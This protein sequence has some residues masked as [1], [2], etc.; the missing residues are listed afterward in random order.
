MKTKSKIILIIIFMLCLLF[1]G[2]K[3]VQAQ[4]WMGTHSVNYEST[5]GGKRRAN[6]RFKYLPRLPN[7]TAATYTGYF[8]M[9]DLT[10]YSSLYS[11]NRASLDWLTAVNVYCIQH[12]NT[13]HT[14]PYVNYIHFDLGTNY[15]AISKVGESSKK[16]DKT[17][18]YA[19]W[20]AYMLSMGPTATEANLKYKV[21]SLGQYSL[22]HEESWIQQSIWKYFNNFLKKA[23]EEGVYPSGEQ[24]CT[25]NTEG[26]PESKAE[27]KESD[28][29]YNYKVAYQKPTQVSTTVKTTKE[30]E[31]TFIGPFKIKYTTSTYNGKLFGGIWAS[32]TQLYDSDGKA[33]DKGYWVL[34]D[35]TKTAIEY[36][37]SNSTFYLKVYTPA[38]GNGLSKLK[39]VMSDLC[40][41]A[42][43]Y[44]VR[45]TYY[46]S[47]QKFMILSNAKTTWVNTDLNIELQG[48]GNIEIT[49]KD[50][51]KGTALE[52]FGFKIYNTDTKKYVINTNP[53]TYGSSSQATVFKTNASGKISV[54]GLVPGDYQA[55]E[56]SV[57]D[58]DG[59]VVP[60]GNS[61]KTSIT[62]SDGKTA[63]K[64]IKNT[65]QKGNLELEK[66]NAYNTNIKLENVE[67]AIKCTSGTQ[68]GKYVGLNSK[69]EVYYSTSKITI[70]T[71]KNGKISIKGIWIGTY[72]LE[73]VSNPHY[74]YV[75]ETVGDIV[76]SSHK[77]TSKQVKNVPTYVKISGYVWLD[78]QYN[79][80]KTTIRN[81][82]Y[83]DNSSDKNDERI[84]GIKVSLMD[85]DKEVKTTTTNANGE[86][87]FEDAEIAKLDDYNIQFEYDGLLYQNVKTN[88]NKDNGSKA[89]EGGRQEFN[90]RF[91]SIERGDS[92]S[93]AVALNSNG[94]EEAKVNYTF[95]QENGG[96]YAEIEST[97][98][99]TITSS[100]KDAK[101]EIPFDK[102]SG[103]SEIENIN[104]GIYE[105]PQTDL[106]IQ[107]ELD[108]VKVEIAG[109]GH[110]YKYGPVYDENDSEKVAE[111]WDLNTRYE[112]EYK[113]IYKRPVY[114]ADAEYVSENQSEM[115]KMALT[116]KITIANQSTLATKVNKIVDYFDAK[117]TIIGI[118]TGIEES[119][120]D[121]TGELSKSRYR[122]VTSESS[123]YKKVE[124]DL[125]TLIQ[126]SSED[127][128]LDKKTQTSIYIQFDLSRENIIEIL[129]ETIS[130][131][132]GAA[133][134]S[135]LRQL[136]NRGD[137]LKNVT[138]ITSFTTYSDTT[139]SILYAAVDSDSVPGNCKIGEEE[140]YEDDTDRASSLAI[141]LA[142]PREVSGK[143]FEDLQDENLNRTMNIA[144]GDSIYDR[145]KENLI[146]GVT[147]Q[148]VDEDENPVEVYDEESEEWKNSNVTVGANTNGTYTISGFIPGKYK[149]KFIWGDGTY[150]II[151]GTRRDEYELMIQNYKSTVIDQNTYEDMEDD[152]HFYKDIETKGMQNNSFA[153][154]DT[155]KRDIIDDEYRTYNFESN[156]T[157][158][159]MESYTPILEANIEY[160][161]EEEMV[162]DEEVIEGKT[163]FK[164]N[165]INLGIIKRPEQSV[166]L[167]KT[168]S[169]IRFILPNG[170]VLIDAQINPDGAVSGQRTYLTYAPP[171]T[172]NGVLTEKG[173]VKIEM[174]SSLLQGS[175]IEITYR[176]DIQNTSQSDYL[177]TSYGY[178]KFGESY[179][180][181]RESFKEN[182]IIT[183]SPTAILD[184]MNENIVFDPDNE[185][186]KQYEWESISIAKLN[187]E[188]TGDKLVNEMTIKA[189]RGNS[190]TMPDGTSGDLVEE[191]QIFITNYFKTPGREIK[192]EFV[193]GSTVK[194]AETKNIFIVG[195]QILNEDTDANFVNQTEIIE[196]TKDGG[197]KPNW[198]P[199]NYIPN[200]TD[201]EVDDG[202]SQEV[203][204]V[205]STGADKSYVIPIT[206]L[207]V[208]FVLLGIGIY[209]II[210]KIM[211]RDFK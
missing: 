60:S 120:G 180:D 188:G 52:G 144:E 138:E 168:V 72:Q 170:Q 47:A 187:G 26:N 55:I 13:L 101:Y 96:R 115:L 124:I 175:T 69:N 184:Y 169:N 68:K 8:N 70:K 134:D 137:T 58:N 74:G 77:T 127:T 102:T 165:D 32:E 3:S 159:T 98:N 61:A 201:Q 155:E 111:S 15:T 67:F 148:L 162:I 150:K 145:T 5:S 176:L 185:I 126:P 80:G 123:D 106:A 209:L 29:F 158:T 125:N 183:I 90:N 84:S 49:K 7:E 50:A 178:Y 114:K 23:K 11:D 193:V 9:T 94:R 149:L 189:L 140:T 95:E 59:Y 203:T 105:R 110:I 1:F 99:C 75:I 208:S 38:T 164:I 192:P 163:S 147:V 28:A 53:I 157:E 14:V 18:A 113:G 173:L 27:Y 186:N 154:D 206:I 136:D 65:Y 91:A 85:G 112:D 41:S 172:E 48:E 88:F 19:Q 133:F 86:Y 35:S 93:Q 121:I 196:I 199:G 73:E 117:Y 205:P 152:S 160:T 156:T 210:V 190:Y 83:N 42:N 76:I 81:D 151:E 25:G 44:V 191:K 109:Y 39:F 21:N 56:V 128:T 131:G 171:K 78:K 122:E 57:G 82:L 62:V 40:A 51:T 146:G 6:V 211:K 195:S 207:A 37:S 71:D 22:A 107:K 92:E 198:V 16:I 100:I 161:D 116:Y 4:S 97:E 104:L 20:I 17:F 204:I 197:G 12:G 177:D 130:D 143:I 139:G 30:G 141:V 34:V 108:Q 54:K 142:E 24:L 202:I 129:N 119:S 135:Q 79:D 166:D 63:K 153:I 194:P 167:V 43:F 118:G 200:E 103:E 31:F 87:Q 182:D 2:V 64:T 181:N 132:E 36:P 46:P 179:Y 89:A 174:D 33:I 10:L 66:V 45:S